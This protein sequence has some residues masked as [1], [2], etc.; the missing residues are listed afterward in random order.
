M[1]GLD[2]SAAASD[3]GACC[4]AG[5]KH[6]VVVSSIFGASL[7]PAQ[8]RYNKRTLYSGEETTEREY[9][10]KKSMKEISTRSM[11]PSRY[12]PLS[13]LFCAAIF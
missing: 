4:L 3:S 5:G 9:C 10:C 13:M 12:Q 7:G 8:H 11:S 2:A 1:D 6:T